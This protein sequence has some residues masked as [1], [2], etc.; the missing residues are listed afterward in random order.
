MDCQEAKQLI[1]QRVHQVPASD[2]DDTAPTDQPDWS[3]LDTHLADCPDCAADLADLLTTRRLL[4]GL[5]EDAPTPEEIEIMW[6]A[7]RTA[8]GID[9]TTAAAPTTAWRGTRLPTAIR[10][11]LSKRLR[12]GPYVGATL[13]TA[14]LLL[15][16]L[17]VGDMRFSE[18]PVI[19][20]H[21]AMSNLR[22][23][24]T[25]SAVY[26]SAAFK[27]AFVDHNQ[28]GVDEVRRATAGRGSGGIPAIRLELAGGKSPQPADGALGYEKYFAAGDDVSGGRF[29][30]PAG[31]D[32]LGKPSTAEKIWNMAY[33]TSAGV[34]QFVSPSMSPAEDSAAPTAEQAL[35]EATADARFKDVGRVAYGYAHAKDQSEGGPWATFDDD[36]TAVRSGD[37]AV[38]ISSARRLRSLGYVGADAAEPPREASQEPDAPPVSFGESYLGARAALAMTPKTGQWPVSSGSADAVVDPVTGDVLQL[39]RSFSRRE[40]N[41]AGGDNAT[42][43]D[44]EH[45]FSSVR[46]FLEV[47]KQDA[48]GSRAGNGIL[49]DEGDIRDFEPD[50]VEAASV[51]GIAF[52]KLQMDPEQIA[53]LESF[54]SAQVTLSYANVGAEWG[55]DGE[56]AE[57]ARVALKNA[58]H[59]LALASKQ[60]GA[61]TAGTSLEPVKQPSKKTPPQP[62]PMA[63]QGPDDDAGPVTTAPPRPQPK[64]IKTGEVEME[65]PDYVE[66]VKLARAMVREVGAYVADVASQEQ[67]G[68]SMMGRLTIR[69]VPERFEILFAALK[70]IGRIEA[71]NVKAADVTAKY[72]DVEARIAAHQATEESLKKILAGKS[73]IDRV[74][75]LLEIERE[76][77][78]VRGEIEKLQGQLRLMGDRISLSTIAVTLREPARTVPTAALSVEVASLDEGSEALGQ[79]LATLDGKLKSGKTSKRDD[80]TLQGDYTLQIR[81]DRFGPLMDAIGGLGRIE[82]RQVSDQQFAEVTA[83]WAER[84]NCAIALVL[85]ERSRQLPSGQIRIEV[86]DVADA[87]DRLD[88]PVAEAQAAIVE[89]RGTRRDDGTNEATLKIRV[90]AGAFAGLV[91]ALDALGRITG[92]QVAGEAGQIVGGAANVMCDLSL[93]L[94][95]RPREIPSGHM[96]IEVSAFE[97]ARKS[98]SDLI[99]EKNVQV[100]GS[101]S[102]QRTDGTWVGG[103]RLGIKAGDMEAVVS[104]LES[105]GRVVSRQIVGLGLGDLSRADPNA[106]GVIE[107]A[108]GEKSAITPGPDRA[109]DSLRSR[110]RDG[111]TG[112]YSS[113]GLILYG[114]VV[115]APWVVIVLVAAW[116][117]TRWHRKRAPKPQ[118]A[119]ATAKS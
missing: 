47:P 19:S 17:A 29:G 52:E 73:F 94:A 60:A 90:P 36:L 20:A 70:T 104:R 102:N 83:P 84:V 86:E 107:V 74:K 2:A 100:L 69:V 48:N 58:Q 97:T 57:Q 46:N 89:N 24:A 115:I 27:P 66:A 93:T 43:F 35:A 54:G 81:M 101:S 108:L 77:A 113:L 10:K 75:D 56:R 5:A 80:G 23:V 11:F 13:G 91:G 39:P 88:A 30:I 28:D 51:A 105:L 14:A 116:A 118:P 112:L 67:A 98:L 76:M 85:Y 44:G 114:L 34:Y 55:P 25:S 42:V 21:V 92:K 72:V 49:G 12:I 61:P 4:T 62:G 110:L 37:E 8:A 22:G 63:E 16:A 111:L 9:V 71:E 96:A 95:E 6:T 99:A 117:I 79:A 106:L 50:Y 68:G 18:Q 87:L 41:F 65:V 59:A 33:A 40:F 26:D 78:R 119:E 1:D 103:F 15:I 82:Q 38:W 64:I 109:G 31:A 53:T 45:D 3:A 7:L 32:A